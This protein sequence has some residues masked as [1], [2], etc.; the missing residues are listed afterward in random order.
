ML[1]RTAVRLALVVVA[2]GAVLAAQA[3]MAGGRTTTTV[4][5][6]GVTAVR[7]VRGSQATTE[8]RS[9]A[10][11]TV[12]GA[13]T[14]I[15]VPAGTRALI[16]V[17]FSAESSC[18]GDTVTS[19]CA[20][21]IMIASSEGRPAAGDDFAF[22]SVDS[23]EAAGSLPDACC[24]ESHSM[25]RSRGPL[26]PGTYEVRVQAKMISAGE[27]PGRPILRL[28]DWSLVVERVAVG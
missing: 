10:Y 14:T 5:A 25:D 27:R 6:R 18:G 8:T 9:G 3:A 2:V 26:G 7:V 22:D 11:H 17:R 13:V 4:E 28:D 15:T 23:S 21:R 12:P 19:Y 1:Q 20:V 24:W 16:L